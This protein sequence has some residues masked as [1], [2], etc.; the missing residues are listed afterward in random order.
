M[1]ARINSSYLNCHMLG[2]FQQTEKNE[3]KKKMRKKDS[4]DWTKYS[5]KRTKYITCLEDWLKI[6]KLVNIRETYS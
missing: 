2:F 5:L 4:L 1:N 3:R 6:V